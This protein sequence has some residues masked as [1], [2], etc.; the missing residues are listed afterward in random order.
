MK[1]AGD[2]YENNTLNSRNPLA[3]FAH[4]RRLHRSVAL[5]RSLLHG[6][7]LLD[8]GCG[9]GSFVNALA[10]AG[11]RAI[12]YDPYMSATLQS[13]VPTFENL[14]DAVRH[15]PFDVVTLFEV[16]EHLSDQEFR[17]FLSLSKTMLARHGVLL[18]SAPIEI[19]PALFLKELNRFLLPPHRREYGLVELIM[20]G[21]FGVPGARAP[22]IKVSH[23]GFDFR[24]AL[25][26]LRDAN[27]SVRVLGFSP[28]PLHSWYGNSQVFFSASPE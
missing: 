18:F 26:A 14:T 5:A 6:G 16:L 2:L 9:A 17:D 21:V 15:G 8:Y 11:E 19:G 12:G 4:R 28:L 3:R 24:R 22:D 13:G 23:K 1:Y 20:A 27:Y 25:G 10:Q 7:I